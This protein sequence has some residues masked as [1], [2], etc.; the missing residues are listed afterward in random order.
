[1]IRNQLMQLLSEKEEEMISLRRHF[2]ENPEISFQEKETANKIASYYEGKDVEIHRNVGNGYGIVVDIKGKQPG[3]TIALRADFDALPILEETDLSFASKNPGVM[4]ACG[5]DGHTAYMMVLADS[6]IQLKDEW[7]GTIKI[8]HQHAEEMAPAGAKSIVES[9]FLDDVDEIY[10]IHFF[11]THEV[12]E[13]F[14][15]SGW[16]FAGCSDLSIKIKGKGGHGSMPHTANDAIVAASSLVMNLQTIVSRRVNPY[17][18]AVLTIGSFEGVGAS[19]VIKDTLILRG[20]ARYM[21]VTV[22]EII[23]KELRKLV[24]GL[25]VSFGVETEVEFLWDY[26][27]VYNHPEQTKKAIK[28]LEEYGVGEYMT[29]AIAA[30]PS[31]GAEDFS[32]YLLKIPGCFINVGCKPDAEE[33][34]LN[35]HPKFDINEKALLVAA[36]AVGDIALTALE[37]Q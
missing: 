4:H 27:P 12:G 21:D 17:D 34:Y 16:A 5:H 35:H 37:M 31:T 11:P 9:G 1:M 7:N 10:G 36:K 33:M 14:Y 23:E 26:P 32:H 28:S 15:T 18:M 2:H 30:P 3:K 13:I 8:V 22:G 24:K 25:E 20:D 29:K 6:L 19:N